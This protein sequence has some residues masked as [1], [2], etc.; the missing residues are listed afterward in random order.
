MGGEVAGVV[1]G[2]M[3]WSLNVPV[4]LVDQK[5]RPVVL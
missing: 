2:G 4:G 3:T 1:T 5:A